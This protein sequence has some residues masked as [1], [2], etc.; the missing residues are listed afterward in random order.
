MFVTLLLAAGML[1]LERS[2]NAYSR[3][4][5]GLVT[6][7]A[8]ALGE[9][10]ALGRR[11]PRVVTLLMAAFVSLFVHLDWARFP[12]WVVALA[13]GGAGLRRARRGD[14]RPSRARSAPRR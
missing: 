1:A 5:R 2:E 8:P 14:R 3:L 12:L 10:S 7:G 13:L 6:P 9:G 4:V 11:A